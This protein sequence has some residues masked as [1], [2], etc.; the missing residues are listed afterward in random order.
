VIRPVFKDTL[1]GDVHHWHLH[2]S[3]P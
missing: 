1:V 2:L 3:V